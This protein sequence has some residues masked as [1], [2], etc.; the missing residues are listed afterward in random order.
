MTVLD[1]SVSDAAQPMFNA[2]AAASGL[3]LDPPF[4]T[5][6]AKEVERA[7]AAAAAA[8]DVLATSSPMARAD[9]LEAIADEILAIGDNLI[10]RAMAE[11]GL[12][13]P[14]LEGERMRTVNQ[15]RMFASFLREG[16]HARVRIDRADPGRAAGPKPDLRLAMVPLG[17][18]AVFGAS[19]PSRWPGAIPPRR[20]LPDVRWW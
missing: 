1:R 14:R 2:V 4:A 12:P 11:T 20:W 7:L 16:D 13:R 15:L 18:V 5:A 10:V 9:L 3:P 6:S 19:W 8:A 17:P